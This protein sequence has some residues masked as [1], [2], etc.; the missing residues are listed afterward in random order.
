MTQEATV[1]TTDLGGGVVEQILTLE[2]FGVSGL[3]SCLL[4]QQFF[5]SVS[6]GA[7]SAAED[8]GWGGSSALI[9]RAAGLC[10]ACYHFHFPRKATPPPSPFRAGSDTRGSQTFS[11]PDCQPHH[12]CQINPGEFIRGTPPC[13][14][15]PKLHSLPPGWK[16][17][18]GDRQTGSNRQTERKE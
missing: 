2:L 15:H 8:L 13:K 1:G 16:T 6:R 17:L 11:H 5:S 4:T 18:E 7:K 9:R 12:G 3:E 10:P 14:G